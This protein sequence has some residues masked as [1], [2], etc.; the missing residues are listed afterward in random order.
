[1]T[2]ETIDEQESGVNNKLF[3]PVVL[4]KD[5]PE[6]GLTAGSVIRILPSPLGSDSAPIITKDGSKM[7]IR[8]SDLVA[9]QISEANGT[10]VI[11]EGSE[12]PANLEEKGLKPGRI[13]VM[14]ATEGQ[15]NLV[16]AVT[17]DGM[18][19]FEI[20]RDILAV[21]KEMDSKAGGK[22]EVA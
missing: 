18:I 4:T 12:I 7:T 16:H 15:G 5:L 14:E 1:M 21:L 11:P 3:T 17:D 20:T 22:E 8:K 2:S 9:M 19:S 10:L 6:H 13:I